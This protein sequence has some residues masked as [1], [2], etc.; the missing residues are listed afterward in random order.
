MRGSGLS[1][2]YTQ[3]LKVN[4]G[5]LTIER[6][7]GRGIRGRGGRGRGRGWF[8][9]LVL[10]IA[11]LFLLVVPVLVLYQRA[12]GGTSFSDSHYSCC[13]IRCVE[14]SL[15][16]STVVG[17]FEGHCEAELF[18]RLGPE[19]LGSSCLLGSGLLVRYSLR[20]FGV[21]A[22]L[23]LGSFDNNDRGTRQ[24]GDGNR[25]AGAGRMR[26]NRGSCSGLGLAGSGGGSRQLQG[27]VCHA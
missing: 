6:W 10:F 2:K 21:P 11:L 15:G 9:P 7:R 27:A 3:R 5:R 18:G 16:L 20:F 17:T 8:L 1:V 13:R 23:E 14:L 26:T 22:G 19:S 4:Q 25:R 24:L 12:E